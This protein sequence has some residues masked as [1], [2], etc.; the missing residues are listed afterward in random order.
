M[1]IDN[2]LAL[3]H[4]QFFFKKA[5]YR[6]DPSYFY[7]NYWWHQQT[8]SNLNFLMHFSGHLHKC[9]ITKVRLLSLAEQEI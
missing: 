8:K 1:L 5:K 6:K 2:L 9:K 3:N 7:E 4:W